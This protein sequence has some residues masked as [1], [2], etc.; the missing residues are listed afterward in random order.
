MAQ[1]LC[2]LPKNYDENLIVGLD[3][4]DDAAVYKINENLALIQTLDFFT[5]VVD[6]PYVFGQIAAANSLSDVY[7]MGGEPKLAMNIVCFP[8]CLD[9]S[10]LVEILKGGY[11]KVKE[12][13]A[14]LVGGHTVEDD[15][16]KYGLSVAGFVHPDKVLTNS[17]AKPGDVL[18]ITKPLGLGIINTAIKGGI[19][20]KTSYDEAVKVMSTLNKFGKEALEKVKVNSVTDIT[21]FGLLGHALEMAE[22][23]EVTI[24]IYYKEIPLISNTLEY[25]RMG[26]VPQG[27]Y[28]NRGYIGDNV[29]FN[30]QIPEEMEDVLFDPQ[31][32]GGLLISVPQK[33][34]DQLFKALANNP[35]SYS[36]IGEV[37]KKE[38]K[39]LI[40]E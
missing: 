2:H 23:S 26:L 19:A 15:E 17:N 12:A 35:I 3:T 39:Y 36:I 20:D 27:A 30:N 34:V 22:S 4:S 29:K 32:S 21:G 18:V 10:V 33:E 28:N 11:D 24:K 38:E 40:V 25:A 1:V 37:V 31:T 14:I 9:P 6:D 8:N 16:P 5:P 13:G 7:A